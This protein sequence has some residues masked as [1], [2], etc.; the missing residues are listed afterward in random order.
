[1]QLDTQTFSFKLA[2]NPIFLFL[3]LMAICQAYQL[4]HA[5]MPSQNERKKFT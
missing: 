5:L 1:M 4:Y 3:H 2:H